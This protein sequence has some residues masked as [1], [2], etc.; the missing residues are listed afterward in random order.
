[1]PD[2]DLTQSFAATFVDELARGGVDAVC[3]APGSRSAPLAMACARHAAVRVYVH[4]DERCASFFALGMARVTRRPVALLCTSGTAAAEFHAAVV[5]ADLSR[6]PLVVLTADRPPEL[7]EVGANQV[8]DQARLYGPSVR[9]YFDPG[10]PTDLGDGGRAWRRLAGRA[11][12][13]SLADPPGPVHLN[14]PL[15]EP[16]VGP[17]GPAPEPLPHAAPPV[18]VVAPRRE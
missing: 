10:P 1:M 8:V 7:R 4:L 15:R 3:L 2:L 18:H 16:L 12:A 14:L 9:W 13:S 6:V 17:P 11:I 5:E